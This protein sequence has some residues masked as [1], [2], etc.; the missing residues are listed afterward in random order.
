M[1]G[2]GDDQHQG[3]R[4][5]GLNG[6]VNGGELLINVVTKSKPKM[7]RGVGRNGKGSGTGAPHSPVAEDAPPAKRQDLTHPG[8]CAKRGKPVS[9]PKRESKLQ[10]EP[11]EMRVGERGRSERSFVMK[12]RGVM[13]LT[14]KRAD[15]HEVF[16][17]ERAWQT[18]EEGKADDGNTADRCS[19]RHGGELA[20][21][22]LEASPPNG[23]SAPGAYREGD[24]RREMGQGERVTIATDPLVQCQSVG[25]EAS[26]GE[27]RK[28]QP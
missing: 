3:G 6:K 26:D 4:G 7:L 13:T 20:E 5:L 23:Q 25:R 27:P 19:L 12:E 21:N 15:F 24:T 14:R 17:H 2:K 18:E 28:V 1:R 10:G 22:A 8:R 9:L 16:H 11:Q